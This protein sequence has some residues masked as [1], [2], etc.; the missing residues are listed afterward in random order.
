M[1]GNRKTCF[2]FFLMLFP[3]SSVGCLPQDT[4]FH[5]ILQPESLPWA[6]VLHEFQSGC[7]PWGAVLQ[8]QTAA[9]WAPHRVTVPARKPGFLSMGLSSWQKPAL[10]RDLH[11]L[12]LPSQHIR[13]LQGIFSMGCSVDVCSSLVLHGLQENNL[14]HHGLHGL[15]GNL[16]S[17][18]WSTFSP[19][20]LAW[21]VIEL[22]FTRRWLD[23]PKQPI[24][25][26]ILYHVMSC[27]VFK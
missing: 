27:S 14:H 25:W 8:E 16:C 7:L 3:C 4:A 20:V 9:V 26:D 18:T 22:I 12:Q 5:K 13:L 2:S 21:A 10:A 6:T 15:Q 23:R 1:S 17:S 19:S 24:K 11:S